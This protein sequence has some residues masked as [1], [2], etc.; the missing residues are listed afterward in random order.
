MR[1]YH[2]SPKGLGDDLYFLTESYHRQNNLYNGK[3][4]MTD[5]ITPKALIILQQKEKAKLIFEHMVPKN[6]YLSMLVKKAQQGIL[7]YAEI[8]NVMMKYYY[9]C[10]VT[11]EEGYLLPS[12]KMQ[13]D[14]DGQNSFYRYQLAGIEFIEN[15]KLF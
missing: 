15:P 12:T 6:L 11:K 10:T 7:T 14:W 9:T 3:Y 1:Q 4:S 2:L 8:Y 5:F 13:E